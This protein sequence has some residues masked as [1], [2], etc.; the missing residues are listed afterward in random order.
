MS[1]DALRKHRAKK[2]AT[3]SITEKFQRLLQKLKTHKVWQ[4]RWLLGINTF[5]LGE[6]PLLLPPP[7][8]IPPPPPPSSIPPPLLP[9][10]KIVFLVWRHPAWAFLSWSSSSLP[11]LYISF[12][13]ENKAWVSCG[14]CL[15][16][17]M[18]WERD[19]SFAGDELG[20]AAVQ[21]GHTCSLPTQPSLCLLH[22]L[23]ETSLD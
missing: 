7:L 9:E 10:Y 18:P 21:Q 15:G 19:V 4:R 22:M 1:H 23:F 17:R 3:W 13:D 2:E 8:P 16:G 20:T 6:C 12:L 5:R 11:S 14:L